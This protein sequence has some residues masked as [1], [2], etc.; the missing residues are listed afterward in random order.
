MIH[1]GINMSTDTAQLKSTNT[2]P[3][4]SIPL[5]LLFG[6]GFA[7][8]YSQQLFYGSL[9]LFGVCIESVEDSNEVI[10]VLQDDLSVLED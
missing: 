9:G 6:N 2:S 1:Y 3:N 10:R 7:F 4:P 8:V 5:I